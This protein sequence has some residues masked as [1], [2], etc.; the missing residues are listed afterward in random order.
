[1][2]Q[3]IGFDRLLG[4]GLPQEEVDALRRQF[5]LLRHTYDSNYYYY[6]FFFFFF[7][8]FFKIFFFKIIF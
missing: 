8:I 3:T 7:L 2:Q 1:M 6:F 5:H 4:L